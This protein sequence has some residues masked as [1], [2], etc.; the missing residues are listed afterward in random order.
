M[1]WLYGLEKKRIKFIYWFAFYKLDS[2]SVRYRAKYPLDYAWHNLDI[3]SHLVIPGYSPSH[4]IQFLKAYFSAL[5]FRKRGSVI[6]I[7]RVR[8]NFIYANLLKILVRLRN[9][10]TI[11]DLDDADYLEYNPRTINYF[12]RHCKFISAGSDEILRHLSKLNSKVLHVT[13]PVYDLKMVKQERNETLTIGWIGEY[14]WG[15][16]ESLFSSAFPAI[17]KLPFACNLVLIGITNQDDQEEV[18]KYFKG[19]DIT[20]R[21][22]LHLDWHNERN[23]QEFIKA[24]DVGLATLLDHPKQ[25]AKS[26]IKA[27]QYLNN[28]VPVLS[29]DLPENNKF[30]R[31]GINGYL[32][33][34]SDDFRKRLIEFHAMTNVEYETFSRNAR[35]SIVN[36]NHE[37]YFRDMEELLS[38]SDS[39]IEN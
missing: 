35:S 29:T 5:L 31:N 18:R 32:C 16:K 6:V 26:G 8:T 15:N 30:V 38:I 19:S 1:H 4:I 12:A 9:K 33:E 21:I 20:V 23:L 13:S 27:K 22:P 17:K 2:P 37:K 28:G 25:I 3:A 14:G 36:F 11:F 34:S 7:Q 10:N 24:F 39:D